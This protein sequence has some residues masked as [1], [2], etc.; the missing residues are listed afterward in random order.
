MELAFEAGEALAREPPHAAGL[1]QDME[2]PE[3]HVEERMGSGRRAVASAIAL[4]DEQNNAGNEDARVDNEDRATA[5][6]VFGDEAGDGYIQRGQGRDNDLIADALLLVG[7]RVGFSCGRRVEKGSVH[8]EQH[9]IVVVDVDHVGRLGAAGAD[10][11]CVRPAQLREEGGPPVG[12]LAVEG[13]EPG[14]LAYD[15]VLEDKDAVHAALGKHDEADDAC[16]RVGDVDDVLLLEVEVR[17]PVEVRDA[18]AFLERA[19]VDVQHGGPAENHP[20]EVVDNETAPVDAALEEQREPVDA[21]LAG[22]EVGREVKPHV[23]AEPQAEPAQQP[24]RAVAAPV[25]VVEPEQQERLQRRDG[26][27]V[28]LCPQQLFG[29]GVEPLGAGPGLGLL[30]DLLL[31]L[32]LIRWG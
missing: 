8:A 16:E 27:S 1:A 19:V 10:G 5:A 24:A 17:D 11:V 18:A 26:R 21:A 6:A 23:E 12:E 9:D 3:E 2:V 32:C 31:G 4:H 28:Q 14:I 15:R 22:G 29:H 25:H 30:L 13:G 20:D 7:K